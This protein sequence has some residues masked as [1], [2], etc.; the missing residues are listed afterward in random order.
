MK[1]KSLV[2]QFAPGDLIVY[3]VYDK[4]YD[5]TYNDTSIYILINRSKLWVENDD[6]ERWDYLRMTLNNGELQF[7]KGGVFS[8]DASISHI[9]GID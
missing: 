3:G 9:F 4:P 8:R 2:Q 7:R 1:P 6:Y 5:L